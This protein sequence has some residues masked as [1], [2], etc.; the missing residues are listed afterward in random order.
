MAHHQQLQFVEIVRNSFPEFFERRTVLELGSWN[1]SGSVRQFFSSCDYIGVDV[2]EGPCVDYVCQGQDVDKPTGH[3]DVVASCECFEHN[4]FWLES[5]VN[6]IRMLKP[7]GLF[8]LS[9]AA[10]GRIE[11][12]TGRRSANQSLTSQ[13]GFPDYYGNLSES[14]FQKRIDLTNH[15][16]SFGFAEAPYYRDL[17]FVGIKRGSNEREELSAR[18]RKVLEAAGRITVAPGVSASGRRQR[19]LLSATS[20]VAETVLGGPVYHDATFFVDKLLGK[21]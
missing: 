17:Y 21:V 16:E 8:I 2:A 13:E 4:R 11:H 7:G 1:V 19:R 14:D 5:F 18:L 9:C 12:G 6:M 15:F 3:F 20:K 10:K